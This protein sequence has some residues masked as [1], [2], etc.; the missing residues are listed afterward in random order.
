MTDP[1]SGP[2]RAEYAM[3]IGGEL[4]QAAD[5]ATIDAVNP[6]TGQVISSFPAATAQD[7][8]LAVRAAEGAAPAWRRRAPTERAALVGRLADAVAAHADELARIDTADN[9][10]LLS[11]MRR[12]A[13]GAV[14]ALRYFAGLALQTS[15]TTLPS[16]AGELTYTRR[17]P[18]GVVGRLVA[19]NHPLLFA[20][21]KIAAPLVA[22]NSVVLKPSEHTS[23]SALRLGELAADILPDGILNVVTGD[24]REA[25]DALVAHPSVRR[26]AFIGSIDTGLAIQRRAAEQ[27]VKTVTL[28][29]G[30]KNP[31]VVFPDA[32]LDTVVDAAVRGMNFTWQGQSC[33]SLSRVLIHDSI[34]DAFVE[35]LTARVAALR[36][37]LPEDPASQTG[38]L[39]NDQQLRKVLH[40]V[41]IGKDEGARLCTGGDRVAEGELAA[42]LFVRPAV[43]ADVDPAS[44]L[45]QEEIFG[46]V[47]SVLRFREEAEAIALANATRFGLTASVFTT[48]LATAHRFAE[49]VDAGYVWVNQVARHIPGAPYGGV[50][51]SGIGSEEDLGELLSYTQ[52]KNIHISYA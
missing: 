30:G 27:S 39:V 22:G 2:V 28:E 20:A 18:Y 41:Q 36:P 1:T 16:P 38:A 12:D 10:S 45:A 7:V 23:L 52:T 48:D 26:L 46:P 11:E 4:R 5:K 44:R 34:H 49:A 33:G 21:S 31:L 3:L 19:F 43:F 51:D 17:V 13:D 6:A 37:G 14:A 9:G 42:G 32:D 35:R 8:D 24:G 15:G 47:L 40:Y 29:L 25:G 50:K